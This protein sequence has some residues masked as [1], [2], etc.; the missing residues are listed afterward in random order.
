MPL[1]AWEMT[2]SARAGQRKPR[3]RRFKGSPRRDGQSRPAVEASRLLNYCT[4]EKISSFLLYLARFFRGLSLIRFP[5]SCFHNSVAERM[6]PHS[7]LGELDPQERSKEHKP[8]AGRL[9]NR[10]FDWPKT[11]LLRRA[12]RT[13]YVPCKGN[14]IRAFQRHVPV[15]SQV[16]RASLAPR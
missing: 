12:K 14:G 1:A 16:F 8:L 4:S 5:G 11:R 7:E 2:Y 10:A 9:L 13:V 6:L 3:G 15:A